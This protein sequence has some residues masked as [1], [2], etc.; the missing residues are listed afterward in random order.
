MGSGNALMVRSSTLAPMVISRDDFENVR[1]CDIAVSWDWVEELRECAAVVSSLSEWADEFRECA[2]VELAEAVV[3]SDFSV[4]D[5]D[6]SSSSL[7]LDGA[8]MSSEYDSGAEV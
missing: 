4:S 3:V 1:E 2:G 6:S 7:M 8:M 5:D